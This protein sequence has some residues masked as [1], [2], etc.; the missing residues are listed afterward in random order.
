M[1]WECSVCSSTK[2]SFMKKLQ[3]FLEDDYNYMK[4]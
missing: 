3:E 4:A 1:S 2:A